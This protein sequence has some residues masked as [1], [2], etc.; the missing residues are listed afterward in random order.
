M[1][2]W[3]YFDEYDV[4]YDYNAFTVTFDDFNP[5]LQNKSIHL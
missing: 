3:I 4:F 5:S 1:F 2:S